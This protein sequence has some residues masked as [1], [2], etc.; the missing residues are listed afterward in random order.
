M[1][2]A[3]SQKRTPPGWLGPA[4]WVHH[5]RETVSAGLLMPEAS[6]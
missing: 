3:A 6:C 2:K 1:L 5:C 4:L